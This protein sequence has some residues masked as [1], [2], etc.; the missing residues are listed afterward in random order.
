MCGTVIHLEKG[1]SESWD[2]H[3][4]AQECES[5][6]Y[7]HV[8]CTSMWTQVGHLVFLKTSISKQCSI[9]KIS[10][11]GLLAH[12]ARLGSVRTD[13]TI[14]E[15]AIFTVHQPSVLFQSQLEKFSSFAAGRSC[16]CCQLCQVSANSC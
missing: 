13:F 16:L 8:S 2:S 7:E 14:H 6:I 9:L 11:L 1:C 12:S 3:S 4:Q 5:Q 10:V 15:I